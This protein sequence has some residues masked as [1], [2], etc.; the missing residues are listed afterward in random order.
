MLNAAEF[1]AGLVKGETGVRMMRALEG[2][3]LKRHAR[4]LVAHILIWYWMGGQRIIGELLG[5]MSYLIALQATAGVRRRGGRYSNEDIFQAQ[6]SLLGRTIAHVEMAVEDWAAAQARRSPKASAAH[7]A[8][9]VGFALDMV[10]FLLPGAVSKV[11]DSAVKTVRKGVKKLEAY[12]SGRERP[13]DDP[14]EKLKD[15]LLAAANVPFF[16]L[17][18]TMVDNGELEEEDR[19]VLAERFRLNMK[20][21]RED[22]WSRD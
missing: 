9:I 13:D 14:R 11:V 2:N 7:G 10:M 18:N 15:Y 17:T 21:G 16:H 22:A 4:R 20:A 1:L 6:A 5:Q 12:E 19:Q 3:N 8:A